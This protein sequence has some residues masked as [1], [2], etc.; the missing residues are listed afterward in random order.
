MTYQTSL[1]M[2]SDG[3]C[4][5]DVE[6]SVVYK[7]VPVAIKTLADQNISADVS[8][9]LPRYMTAEFE[10]EQINPTMAG[11]FIGGKTAELYVVGLDEEHFWELCEENGLDTTPYKTANNHGILL[12]S[13]TGS[14]GRYSG[15]I[16]TGQPF[17]ITSGTS[18]EFNNKDGENRSIIVQDIINGDK[19]ASARYVRDRAVLIVPLTWYDHIL[20]HDTYI[21][22]SITTLQ[23]KEAAECLTDAGFFQT[24]DV[25]GATENTR[26]IYLILKFSVCIFAV[27]ITMI[28]TLNVCNTMSN[29]IYM[30]RSEFAVLRSVGMNQTGLKKML[31]LEAV[32]YGAKALL[33]PTCS[34]P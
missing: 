25:A 28:I 9:H 15:R 21:Q 4:Y 26:Q 27:L 20:N 23:H 3:S 19:V 5:T 13:A 17:Q 18:I 8:W 32:L 34:S 29:T 16:I 22:M 6:A 12:N 31:F 10:P 33:L 2:R 11:Y 30:R 1:D 14:F 7:D 24:F